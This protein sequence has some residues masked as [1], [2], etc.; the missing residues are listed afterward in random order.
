[1]IHTLIL[2]VTAHVPLV[3]DKE[4]CLI[5]KIISCAYEV[6]TLVR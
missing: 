2:Q 4:P 1:M 3:G 6:V 5:R